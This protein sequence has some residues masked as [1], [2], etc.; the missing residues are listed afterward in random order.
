MGMSPQSGLPHNNRIGDFD[1]FAIPLIIKATG[2]SLDQVLDDLACRS[3]LLGLSGISGDVRDLEQAAEQGN[4]R[5]RLALDVLVAD[6]RRHLGGLLVV[7]GGADAIVFTGGIGENA[8]QLRENVCRGLA[9]LGIV[10]DTRA[11]RNAQGEA[12]IDASDSRTQIWIVPTNEELIVARQVHQL[13]QSA[14]QG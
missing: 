9:Q 11:N 13:L 10:L 7:L 4:D 3:G 5:A 12:R 2:K 8:A 1:P 6:I 14:E